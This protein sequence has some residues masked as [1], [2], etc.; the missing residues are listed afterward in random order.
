MMISYLSKKHHRLLTETIMT[1]A[2]VNY[3]QL[4]LVFLAFFVFGIAGR[5]NK[6]SS[7]IK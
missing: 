5:T 3:D 4:F 1:S 6:L 7:V 2:L